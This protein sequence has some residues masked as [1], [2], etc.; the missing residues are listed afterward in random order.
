MSPGGLPPRP[1]PARHQLDAGLFGNLRR[2]LFDQVRQ[3]ARDNVVAEGALTFA[4][5]GIRP[6]TAEII[7]PTYLDR[8]RAHGRFRARREA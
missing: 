8:F 5:L 1:Q 4:D 3:L 6:K 7:L 2:Q